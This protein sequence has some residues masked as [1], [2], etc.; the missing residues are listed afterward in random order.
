MITSTCYFQ[1]QHDLL[2][3][4]LDFHSDVF[5]SHV[6]TILVVMVLLWVW[7]IWYGSYY[8]K[9][10][11]DD[12]LRFPNI[13]IYKCTVHVENVFRNSNQRCTN[14]DSF[15]FVQGLLQHKFQMYQLILYECINFWELW[16][17]KHAEIQTCTSVW[18]CVLWKDFA[19]TNNGSFVNSGRSEISY[20]GE[21]FVIVEPNETRWSIK[22]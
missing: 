2:L 22:W 11:T 9:Q 7:I 21:L 12:V 20:T 15:F 3:L 5:H 1:R 6:F 10:F 4:S 17:W 14:G 18:L 16:Q 8:L 13:F 19:F